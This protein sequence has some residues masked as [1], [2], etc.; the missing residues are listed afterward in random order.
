MSSGR[1]HGWCTFRRQRANQAA[2]RVRIT[3]PIH[4]R[5][6]EPMMTT[7]RPR[8][9]Y[10]SKPLSASSATTR[11]TPRG[12]TARVVVGRAR[13]GLARAMDGRTVRGCAAPTARTRLRAAM[14]RAPPAVRSQVIKADPPPPSHCEKDRKVSLPAVP[15]SQ[16]PGALLMFMSRRKNRECTSQS[17]TTRRLPQRPGSMPSLPWFLCHVAPVLK[18]TPTRVSRRPRCSASSTGA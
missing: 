18:F 2:R 9:E 5:T 8:N 14:L 16:Q 6:T 1:W 7:L 4:R 10:F 3:V 11:F 17:A 13:A 15:L 12:G